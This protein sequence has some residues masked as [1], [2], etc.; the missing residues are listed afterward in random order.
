MFFLFK[1][2]LASLDIHRQIWGLL[3]DFSVAE[4][5]KLRP[6]CPEESFEEKFLE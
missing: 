5:T 1:K 3:S 4:L 2:K 6:T